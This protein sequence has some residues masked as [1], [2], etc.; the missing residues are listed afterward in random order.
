MAAHDLSKY[1]SLMAT[2]LPGRAFVLVGVGLS[3]RPK[4]G[5]ASAVVAG[6]HSEAFHDAAM[7]GRRAAR[8]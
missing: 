5:D 6:W 8:K 3:Q 7:A 4:K 2:A 1:P